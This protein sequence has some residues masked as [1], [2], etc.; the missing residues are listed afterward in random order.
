MYVRAAGT[1]HRDISYVNDIPLWWP[2]MLWRWSSSGPFKLSWAHH[3]TDVE[4][5]IFDVRLFNTGYGSLAEMQ[6]D[7]RAARDHIIF[8]M[9]PTSSWRFVL[10]RGVEPSRDC[11]WY[12]TRTPIPLQDDPDYVTHG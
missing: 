1:E 6:D 4:K 11:E 9:T 5:P 3:G 7:Y 8:A 10:W 12:F 2:L